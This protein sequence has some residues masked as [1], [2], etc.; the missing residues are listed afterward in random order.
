MLLAD[1]FLCVLLFLYLNV[2]AGWRL[3]CLLSQ[4]VRQ[5]EQGALR[6]A[7]LTP[8]DNSLFGCFRW[9]KAFFQM[10]LQNCWHGF[11]IN[12]HGM[13]ASENTLVREKEGNKH[14]IIS[15][16]YLFVP[17]PSEITVMDSTLFLRGD[18]VIFCC[19]EICW[20]DNVTGAYLNSIVPVILWHWA[21]CSCDSLNSFGSCCTSLAD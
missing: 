10:I 19:W 3:I 15:I 4:A 13:I 18:C 5:D 7:L 8:S 6:Y 12:S 14:G 16:C 17:Q 9:P 20:S 11:C 21:H 1:Y 2:P